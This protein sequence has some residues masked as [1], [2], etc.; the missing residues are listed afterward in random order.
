MIERE[1][2]EG[3]LEFPAPI[4]ELSSLYPARADAEW[5]SLV[6]GI[7]KG[8]APE[9]ARRREE[10]GLV[11]SILRWARP[12]SVAAAAVLLVGSIGLAVTNDAEAMVTASAPSFA[13]VVDREPAST[14]LA[15]DLPP[16]ASDLERALE[17]D[18]LE[19]VHP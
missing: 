12:V 6:R 19:T 16:S 18:S 7:M 13:E 14:L 3:A 8:A 11:R 1:E 9:L 17:S 15:S 4:A 5:D 2:E 10:R